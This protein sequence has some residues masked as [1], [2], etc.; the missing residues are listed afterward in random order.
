M[1]REKL[2]FKKKAIR[3]RIEIALSGAAARTG[4]ES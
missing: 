2:I 1:I 4:K 3:W